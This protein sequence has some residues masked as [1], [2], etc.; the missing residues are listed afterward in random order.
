MARFCDVLEIRTPISLAVL[1]L[2]CC[3]CPFPAIAQSTLGSVVGSVRDPSGAAVAA[4]KVTLQ[5][6]GTSAQRA[7]LT[8]QAGSYV[9]SNMEPGTYDLTLEAPGFQRATYTDIEL[10]S[11]QTVRIDGNLVVA[12]Q[13][14][15]VSVNAASE[16]V[17]NTDVSNIA[18]TKTGRELVDLPVAVASRST[19]STSPFATLTTQ[20]GVQIDSSGNLSV[21]GSKP[22]MLSMSID[23]IS[24]MGP[25]TSAPLT[26]LFPSFNSISEIRVSEF[27][28][29]A[30][31]GGISDVTTISKS[32]TNEFHGGFSEY[33]ENTLMNARNTFSDTTP[34][35]IMND[36]GG[37][38]GGPVVLPKLYNG[39]NRTFFFMSYEGLRLPSETVRVESV[40]SLAMRSGDLSSYAAGPIYAPGSGIPY[41]NDII[42]ASEIS[43]ISRN[44]LK[45]LFPLPNAG[46][47]GSSAN[48]FVQNAP[49]PI[50]SNQGDFRL[51]QNI[52]SKQS[53]FGRFTYKN[54]Q[55]AAVPSTNNAI[56]TIT[57]SPLLGEFSTPEIDYGLTLAYTIILSPTVVNE[58]RFG[59]NGNHTGLAFGVTAP[60]IASELGLTGLPQPYPGGNA[61]PDY[62]IAGFM[63][64]G[65]TSS[66]FSIGDTKQVL[67]NVTWTRG[68]HTLKFGGDYR[69]FS[70]LW[71]N[72]YGAQRLGNYFF[73][74]SV[75]SQGMDPSQA[76]SA[77]NPPFIGDPFAGFLLG[78]PDKTALDTVTQPDSHGYANAY[79]FFVQDDWKVTSRLTFNYGLRWEYHPM[80][81]DHLL[82]STNFLPDYYSVVN[83]QAVRG[84]AVIPSQQ[85]FGILN[86]DFAASIYPTPIITAQQAGIPSSLRYSQKTDFAPRFGFAWR[87]FVDGKTVIR[88]GFGRFI[89]AE[90]G[91]LLGATYCIHAADQGVFYQQIVNG[92]PT[93]TFP[94]PFPSN[95]AQPG[96]QYFQQA[97]ALHYKDPYVQEWNFTIERDLGLNTALQISYTGSHGSDLGVQE[98]LNQVPVNRLG[99]TTVQNFAPFPLFAEMQIEANGGW[100]NYHSLTVATKKRF[101]NGLQF[102]ASYAFTR[103]LSSGQSWN[104]TSFATEAG[105][106][107]TDLNNIGLDY[108]NVPFTH[109]HRFLA[110]FLYQLPFGRKAAIFRNVNPLV[111]RVIGGWELAGVL[112]FQTGP[113]LTITVPG[114]DPSGTGFPEI[115][116]NGR[117][118]TVS[119]V[120][121][122]VAHP[123]WDTWL[124]PA[125][126]AVPPD[127]VG[128]WGYASVGSV[129]GPGTESVSASLIKTVKFTERA[130]LQF[131][132]Q[133]A[134]LFNHPNYAAPNTTFNTPSFG[135]LSNLQSAEG[136]GPRIV[137]V[138]GRFNF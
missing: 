44:V 128:R 82:N 7:T 6:K 13:A 84:A 32:G 57:G 60:Q 11:R 34:K 114:A 20:P 79:A 83:G 134:N 138:T 112:L 131:G 132:A 137:Q 135:T 1:A 78:I 133:V 2:I 5:N 136:A 30:E 64:P 18:E 129:V 95:L 103:N 48:N 127:N 3:T 26:E 97:Q 87:P 21:A 75:T 74:G 22:A 88:G 99:F 122:Y 65:G 93:L 77:S 27:N 126:F 52:N 40:P 63:E 45:Y 85:A 62:L 49:T 118:D 31:F 25:F 98:N 66:T 117:A 121:P 28:N 86:K 4:C 33:L 53:V 120:S 72:V 15:S 35:L 73:N 110:T 70:G 8:D 71:T 43:P 123:R 108:G 17:I 109:R 125:A 42:P 14:Q 104:P 41:A 113:F 102:Q 59:F 46:P 9:I 124:N 92:K 61:V 51:D 105:G 81:R 23:G 90:L 68:K 119:G 16:P 47:A 39:R 58:A 96:S 54:R 67:D 37:F 116:G 19:G 10:L 89:E 91:G 36:F 130:R 101:T 111:D 55:V 50:S 106:E 29:T 100:S 56:N 107:V 38:L 94:Y 24:S 76:A 69:R 12:T 80:F 115:I